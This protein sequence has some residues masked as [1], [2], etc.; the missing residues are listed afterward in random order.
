MHGGPAP[1]VGF[2]AMPISIECAA[3]PRLLGAAVAVGA[4]H[5]RGAAPANAKPH[6]HNRGDSRQQS[7]NGHSAVRVHKRAARTYENPGDIRGLDRGGHDN[8]YQH[9]AAY[10]DDDPLQKRRQ[11]QQQRKRDQRGRG[12]ARAPV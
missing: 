10:I 12:A 4:T 5:A 2:L 8:A 11:K 9:Q 6:D 7:G 1:R 3:K